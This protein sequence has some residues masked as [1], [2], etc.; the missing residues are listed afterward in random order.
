MQSFCIKLCHYFTRLVNLDML[1]QAIF[2]RQIL[3]YVEMK[4]SVSKVEGI[5]WVSLLYYISIVKT[6]VQVKGEVTLRVY[7][8]SFVI[9]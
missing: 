5:G 1:L 3:E 9:V 4:D 6:T 2:V 7:V 8:Y